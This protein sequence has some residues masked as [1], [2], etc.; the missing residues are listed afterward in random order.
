MSIS[1]H[2]Q[3]RAIQEELGQESPDKEI[4]NLRLKG[5]QK[6]GLSLCLKY[7]LRSLINFNEPTQR[8]QIIRLV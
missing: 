3:I 2:Q 8:H 7:I 1:L 6:T 4:E 5:K